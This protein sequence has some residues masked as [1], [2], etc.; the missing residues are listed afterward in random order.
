M[1]KAG[2]NAELDELTAIAYSG[3]DYLL[4]LQEREVQRTGISSLKVAYNKVFGYYLEVTHAHKNRVP[5]DWIRKQTLV[6]AERYITPELKEYEEKI[7]NAEEQIFQIEARMFNEMVM[8]AGEYVGAIQQNARVLSV[9]DVLASFARVAVKNKY[10]R[11]QINESKVLNIKDGRHPVIEQ[12]LPP[13]E[14]YIPNDIFL[15]DET[16]Q[17]I[18]ITGPNMAGK[19]ALATANG[20][21]CADGAVGKFCAGIVWPKLGLSTRFLRGLALRITSRGAKVRSWSR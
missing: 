3:K 5:E 17:I 10:V 11:P 7:L 2:I 8:A 4:Q 21:D 14:H 9:L 1:I 12:Q 15:D 19:S 16:Q 20:P 6:N 18:I 13:G